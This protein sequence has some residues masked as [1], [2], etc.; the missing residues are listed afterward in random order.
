MG[1]GGEVR[2]GRRMWKVKGYQESRGERGG[3][4]RVRKCGRVRRAVEVGEQEEGGEE[5]GGEDEEGEVGEGGEDEGE[6]EEDHGCSEYAGGSAYDGG[7]S[8]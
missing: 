1:G 7:G 8:G 4:R 5:Q 6:E 3:R 2:V